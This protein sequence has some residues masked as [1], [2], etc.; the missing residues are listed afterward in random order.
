MSAFDNTN[1]GILKAN[2]T[3][4]ND[5]DPLKRFL[6]K[7]TKTDHCW[8][9]RANRTQSGYGTFGF[10]RKV[11]RAHRVSYVLFIGEI[12][13]GICV[14]HRCD[15]PHCVNPDHLFLGTHADNMRDAQ[16]KGR[17]SI[18][19]AIAAQKPEQKP[20]GSSHH[21][22]L[23]DEARVVELRNLRRQ[24]W[25]LKRLAA[26]FCVSWQQVQRIACG[27]DWKHVPG[28]VT[29]RIQGRML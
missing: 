8:I 16:A 5:K 1:T 15:T 21:A 12:P 29:D 19:E 23:I 11:W 7:V 24:G 26:H 6:S 2:E 25:A 20:R 27:T 13:D 28:A 14:C 9:W 4:R 22:A 17:L 10:R 3:R 18:K